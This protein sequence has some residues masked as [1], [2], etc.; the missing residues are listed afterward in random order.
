MLLVRSAAG[1]HILW[2]VH[3]FEISVMDACIVT[4][5]ILADRHPCILNPEA[6][7][8]FVL[9]DWNFLPTDERRKRLDRP[10]VVENAVVGAAGVNAMVFE[11]A[12]MDFT[13]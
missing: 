1:T 12:F 4:E 2:N 7:T 5:D 6:I 11:G 8:V 3:N 9:G 10:D 13:D